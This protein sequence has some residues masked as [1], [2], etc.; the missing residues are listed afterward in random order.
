MPSPIV[1]AATIC[2]SSLGAQGTCIATNATPLPQITDI[3]TLARVPARF[4]RVKCVARVVQV[5]RGDHPEERSCRQRQKTWT[6][7]WMRS[8]GMAPHL[9]RMARQRQ[10]R[11]FPRML[12]WLEEQQSAMFHR[13]SVFHSSFC[14]IYMYDLFL[15]FLLPFPSSDFSHD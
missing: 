7:N 11:P 8:W 4:E 6:R 9:R 2:S 3:G 10:G 1:L 5:V 15:P 13:S 12:I 14:I